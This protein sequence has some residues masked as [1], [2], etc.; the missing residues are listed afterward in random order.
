MAPTAAPAATSGA[1]P[2][3]QALVSRM[4]A[5]SISS[6]RFTAG[7]TVR[8]R[9]LPKG[10][11]GLKKFTVQVAGEESLTTPISA[12]ITTTALGKSI[13]SRIVGGAVYVEA[14]AIAKHD[15]GKPWVKETVKGSD[16]LETGPGI[17]QG[18]SSTPFASLATLVAS[19]KDVNDLGPATV[20]GQTVT[21]ISFTIPPAKLVSQ[22]LATSLRGKLGSHATSRL[23]VDLTADG[24][25]VHTVGVVA[26]GKVRIGLTA[27]ISATDF[28]LTVQPPPAAE[29]ITAKELLALLKKAKHKAS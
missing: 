23:E 8:P 10:F 26:I 5:L 21:R 1:T 7:V 6:E 27:D 29:T 3:I 19:G 15:G 2:E 28:P 9:K 13:P 12:A 14:P 18:G 4:G 20:D 17:G 11:E 22:K 16:D 25:P 24:L